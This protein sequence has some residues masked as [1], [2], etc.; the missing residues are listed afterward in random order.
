MQGPYALAQTAV[1]T[2]IWAKL[3]TRLTRHC[4][5]RLI[6]IHVHLCSVHDPHVS[7]WPFVAFTL[8][9]WQQPWYFTD[10]SCL[11]SFIWSSIIVVIHSIACLAYG[12]GRRPWMGVGA[13]TPGRQGATAPFKLH[14]SSQSSSEYTLDRQ[15]CPCS[16][17][18]CLN[19]NTK[20]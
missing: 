20:G 11:F 10:S 2:G 6:Y 17:K 9:L 12:G 13:S 3:I 18:S 14:F 8:T 7:L 19:A 4:Q 15:M 16:V 1:T 5:C